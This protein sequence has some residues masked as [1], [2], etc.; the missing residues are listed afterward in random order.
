MKLTRNSIITASPSMCSPIPNSTPPLSHQV[1]ER[2]TGATNGLACSSP[3]PA[4]F[5]RWI[6][7]MPAPIAIT[8]EA[9]IDATPTSEPCIGS[10]L[11]NR[12]M[13]ANAIPGISGI[14]HALFRNHPTAIIG[15][16][17]Q[18]QDFHRQM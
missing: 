5:T 6:H 18:T 16:P 17:P 15:D 11:P 14:N 10:F 4:S 9:A 13:T 2:T 8:V 12:M 1:H 3:A 7:W